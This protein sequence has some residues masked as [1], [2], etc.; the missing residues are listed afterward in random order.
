[1]EEALDLCLYKFFNFFSFSS[2]A[3]EEPQ[4]LD[5]GVIIGFLDRIVGYI[6]PIAGLL[7]VAFVI[8][9]GY[10]WIISGGDPEKLKKAQGTLTWAIIGLVFT[11]LSRV[12]LGLI[13]KGLQ[14]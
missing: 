13:Y 6:F 7:A 11:I 4:R 9:G 12:I 10:M 14:S 2:F 5:A 3:E 1:M 8:Y